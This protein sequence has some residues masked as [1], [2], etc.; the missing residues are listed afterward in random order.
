MRDGVWRLIRRA[1]SIIRLQK[2]FSCREFVCIDASMHRFLP[3]DFLCTRLR[4]H[5]LA[6]TRDTLPESGLNLGLCF[7]DFLLPTVE[8]SLCIY[9]P[10]MDSGFDA[11]GRVARKAGALRAGSESRGPCV[12][13]FGC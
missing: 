7:L 11:G 6:G 5:A 13:L 12:D 3:S 2:I 1:G 9:D 8:E 4:V 10:I